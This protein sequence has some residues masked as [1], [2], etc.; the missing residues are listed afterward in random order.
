MKL[1]IIICKFVCYI[2]GK[3]GKG[4]TFP[5]KLAY[6]LNPK[7]VEYFKM[8]PL[9][10]AVTGSAGKG[11]VSGIVAKVLETEGK[12]VVYNQS[13]SNMLPGI[14]TLLI[15]NTDFKGNIK[16][17]VLVAEVD[18]RNTSKVFAMLQPQYVVVTNISRD[19]P[20]RHGNVDL[21]L[22]KIKEA[23]KPS[24]HLIL[25]AD[26][27]YLQNI[28]LDDSYAVTYY[29]IDRT[30]LSYEEN[31]FHS[32]NIAYCPKCHA[33][34]NYS[35]YHIEALGDYH[36]HRCDFG[37]PTVAYL[38]T[39]VEGHQM[40]INQHTVEVNCDILYHIYNVLTAYTVCSLVGIEEEKI[41][42]SLA[43]INRN[44]KLY[45]SFSFHGKDVY[46]F[47]NKNENNMTFNQSVFYTSHQKVDKTI[48]VGWKEI[49]RRYEHNDMSWLYDIEFELL[50]NDHT[51]KVIC[52]GRDRYDIATRMKYAGI[53]ESKIKT[54]ENLEEAAEEIR[55]SQ[56]A[57][58]AILNFDYVEPFHQ[59]M[60]EE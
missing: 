4:S 1:L 16:G 49:S 2:L 59:I 3:L 28:V 37:R 33:K 14:L 7:I 47:N 15:Q 30:P 51:Q 55:A 56:H 43:E 17:D 22:D 34:L 6:K 21:V 23:L 18:E 31:V 45:D 24:M 38:A 44:K 27:P 19:Q 41:C 40:K 50:Q 11:S 52:V 29:G 35:Y 53:P 48:V 9:V 39:E 8:P 13:G 32:L 20:P 5:G 58:F 46:V 60:K 42:H 12:Q 57:I 26:D 54:Y 10:I 36:C 25:N